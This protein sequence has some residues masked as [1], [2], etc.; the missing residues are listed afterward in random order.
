MTHTSCRAGSRTVS[1]G[2]MRAALAMHCLGVLRVHCR[3]ARAMSIANE[4]AEIETVVAR[5]F[6]P[7][8]PGLV[9]CNYVV[10]A[11]T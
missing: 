1:F 4:L 10:K 5:D 9:R 3:V 6:T 11:L 7:A 8:L 2:N